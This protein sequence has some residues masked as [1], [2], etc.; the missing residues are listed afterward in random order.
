MR[1]LRPSIFPGKESD[2]SSP[3]I[4]FVF[5]LL[6]HHFIHGILIGGLACHS[7][8]DQTDLQKLILSSNK[9]TDIGDGVATLRALTLLDAHDNQIERVSPA[10]A[11]L[12]QLRTLNL[13]HN[14]LAILPDELC[15]LRALSSLRIDHN[16]LKSLPREIGALIDLTELVRSTSLRAAPLARAKVKITVKTPYVRVFGD[17]IRRF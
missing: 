5:A 12:S 3:S 10:I 16:K 8:W 14:A 6:Y 4:E 2:G 15:I 9:L 1:R 13:S 11:E 7:R 17:S